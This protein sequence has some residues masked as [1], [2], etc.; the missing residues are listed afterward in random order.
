MR[1]KIGRVHKC[2]VL[3]DMRGGLQLRTGHTQ[4]TNYTRYVRAMYNSGEMC[5]DESKFKQMR[6]RQHWRIAR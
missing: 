5:V 1:R 2:I 4:P 3:N 6:K